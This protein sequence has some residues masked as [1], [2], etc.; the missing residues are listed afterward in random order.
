[1]N[2]R[3]RR[4]EVDAEAAVQWPEHV[5]CKLQGHRLAKNQRKQKAWNRHCRGGDLQGASTAP[6]HCSVE[7]FAEGDGIHWA[8][9][10]PGWKKEARRIAE[11]KLQQASPEWGRK[12]LKRM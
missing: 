7:S 8:Y 1:M 3:R 4:D 10:Y 2:S 12:R 9:R 11:R 5:G 6:E